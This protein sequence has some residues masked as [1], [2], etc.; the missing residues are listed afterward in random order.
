MRKCSLNAMENKDCKTNHLSSTSGK[1]FLWGCV[2]IFT[3]LLWTTDPYMIATV[4]KSTRTTE[5][6][7]PGL[8]A[9][10]SL[11]YL[12]YSY[13]RCECFSTTDKNIFFPLLPPGHT[14]EATENTS[15]G[16]LFAVMSGSVVQWSDNIFEG[17]NA[18]CRS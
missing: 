10:L 5:V 13:Y 17:V 1:F 12:K 9:V 2:K 3:G 15:H 11:T 8:D 6:I 16:Y 18:V 4:I 14:P 7:F